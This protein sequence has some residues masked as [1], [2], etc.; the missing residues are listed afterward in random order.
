MSLGAPTLDADFVTAALGEALV[1]RSGGPARFGR[2][3]IDSR[4]AAPGD[5]FVALS[6]KRRRGE[7]FAAEAVKRGAAGLL[8]GGDA[9][10]S[11]A[12]GRVTRFYV[13]D[14]LAGLQTLAVAWRNALPALE[15]VGV[16]GS[17]GKT[18]T[19]L[20]TAAVLRARYRVQ[21][22]E[23]N[24][25][26]EI[27]V[28]LCLLELTTETRR[29]VIEM[30]MYTTGEIAKLAEWTRPRIG[31]V[32]NVQPVHLERAGTLETI[33]RAKRELVEAL[34]PEGHAVLNADDPVVATMARHTHARVWRF[35]AR[36]GVD[37][38]GTDAVSRGESGFEFTLR[39]AG[40]ER[41]VTVPLPGAHL[42][43]NVLAAVSVALADGV[44]LDAIVRALQALDVP[45]RLTIRRLPAGIT[46]LDDTYNASPSATLAAL[47]LLGEMPGRRVAMLGDM[48]ELGPLAAPLHEQ[49]GRRAAAEAEVL[50][51]VGELAAAIA[52][53]AHAGGLRDVRHFASKEE[54]TAALLEL[55]RPGDAVLVK[56]SRALALETVVQAL[57]AAPLARARVEAGG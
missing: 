31:V 30:G 32:L 1:A 25:N 43:S 56:G 27:G 11:P 47:D 54:A 9:P 16:T 18:T 26:N 48:L 37:V 8:L 23:A 33:A 44:A 6:G 21:A 51:T 29:A 53:A 40:Q 3:V 55:I 13:D 50:L 35:G 20:I 10:P 22:A 39:A 17:V 15:V 28:P 52:A 19:K 38:R 49:V 41:R 57:E 45:L 12:L 24:Y 42:L 46:L 2:A 36:E 34:P 7:D 5:L 4:L 14:A